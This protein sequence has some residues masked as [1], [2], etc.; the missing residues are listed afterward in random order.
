M[1]PHHDAADALGKQ[2]A[3]E[4]AEAAEAAAAKAEADKWVVVKQAIETKNDRKENSAEHDGNAWT[5]NMPQHLLAE[6]EHTE[7]KKSKKQDKQ[8]A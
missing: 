4:M 6:K 1:K 8:N 7:T 2:A 3:K 5:A